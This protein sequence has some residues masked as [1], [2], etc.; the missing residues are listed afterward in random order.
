MSIKDCFSNRRVFYDL[1]RLCI[2]KDC[3]KSVEKTYET[4]FPHGVLHNF[5]QS[6]D[7]GPQ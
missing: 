2:A 4:K 7:N 6:K 3:I 5:I 1:S